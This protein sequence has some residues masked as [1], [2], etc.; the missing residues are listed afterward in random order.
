MRALSH[1]LNRCG[2]STSRA[3][4]AKVEGGT[5]N[6]VALAGNYTKENMQL[7]SVDK[8]EKL[9]ELFEVDEPPQWYLR[10]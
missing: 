7:P 5:C 3:L 1:I 2:L 4:T 6:I 9:K 10:K 8:I